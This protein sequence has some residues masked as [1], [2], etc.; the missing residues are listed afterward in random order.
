V[1]WGFGTAAL[2]TRLVGGLDPRGVHEIKPGGP[3]PG[4]AS[5]ADRAAALSLALG[6]AV[7][8]LAM[9]GGDDRDCSLPLL[10]CASDAVLAEFGRPYLPGL[11]ALGLDPA[12]LILVEARR[13][14][15]I[16]GAIE[17]GLRSSTVALVLALL[18]RVETTPA[19]RLAL[20]AE[21]GETP[22]LLLTGTRADG[23]RAVATRWRVSAAPSA[24]QPFDPAAPGPPRHNVVLER[25]RLGS[26]D[27]MP[28][29]S[30]LEWC[31]ETHRFRV[32]ADVA[33]RA[34]PSPPPRLAAGGRTALRSR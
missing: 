21:S 18:E 34:L 22:C 32:A 27:S 4:R 26:V 12:H 3:T 31:H 16:L 7:R 17:E 30:I 24:P 15:D 8:R 25:C 29:P 23:A 19:R 14:A 20:A 28:A 5:A 9:L 2:D 10:I 33:D 1:A 11:L 13:E 6:L